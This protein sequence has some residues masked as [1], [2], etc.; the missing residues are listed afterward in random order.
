MLP[1]I[2]SSSEAREAHV[3]R[4]MT[5]SEQGW[6]SW[7]VPEREELVA[8]KPP[9][10]H[11]LSAVPVS[12]LGADP[13]ISQRMVSLVSALAMIVLVYCFTLRTGRY[14][15]FRSGAAEESA[16]FA[17]LV[18]A[19]SYQFVR[20]SVDARVDMLFSLLVAYASITVINMSRSTASHAQWYAA[21]LAF[22]GAVLAKGPLGAAL[23]L[24]GSGAVIWAEQGP[25]VL[26][27]LFRTVP[28]PALLIALSPG[29][30]YLSASLLGGTPFL[31]RH[32]FENVSR[33][34]GGEHIT[35]RPWWYYVA[36]W[37]RSAFPWSTLFAIFSIPLLLKPRSIGREERS[38]RALFLWALVGTLLLS[39]SSGK[40]HSYLLP[41]YVPMAAATSLCLFSWWS[42]LAGR[43]RVQLSRLSRTLLTAL[44]V[45]ALAL[46][47]AIEVSASAAFGAD[48]VLQGVSI[49]LREERWLLFAGLSPLLIL[50]SCY[51]V[52]IRGLLP[53][54]PQSMLLMLL[55]VLSTLVFFS[56]G[57]IKGVKAELKGFERFAAEVEQLIP[58]SQT[59]TAI[60]GPYDELLDPLLYYIEREIDVA[61]PTEAIPSCGQSL[62][63]RRGERNLT[64][65]PAGE[66]TLV[67]QYAHDFKRGREDR[68]MELRKL[69]ECES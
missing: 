48:P 12:L 11:W 16:L 59:I 68:V 41:L 20:L 13:L 27:K 25:G 61:A 65:V 35:G 47:A 28:V 56:V 21:A 49:W 51:A 31:E 30:W 50:L 22:A 40:R 67:L 57:V 15:G 4:D 55:S 69:P 9:L 38:T 62:L 18:L 46:F 66:E 17:C 60:R 64:S 39:L 5:R 32:F 14:A 37:L 7:L 2:E 54:Q 19:T 44:A 42:S 26:R 29:L 33:L 43:C 8:S 52:S 34:S 53:Y 10:A 24:I 1:S 3:S 58:A 45:I 36:S 23:V 6:Q 63:Y